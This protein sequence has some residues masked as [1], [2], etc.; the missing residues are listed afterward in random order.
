M[1]KPIKGC[2]SVTIET[3]RYSVGATVC[4]ITTTRILYGFITETPEESSKVV[5]NSKPQSQ[6]N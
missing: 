3:K 2:F 5:G 1:R 4:L 6:K